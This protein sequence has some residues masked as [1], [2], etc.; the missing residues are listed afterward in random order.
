MRTPCP[1]STASALGLAIT[2]LATPAARSDAPPAKPAPAG[3]AGAF[4][5]IAPAPVA[6]PDSAGAFAALPASPAPAVLPRAR[7]PLRADLQGVL[8][9]EQ[10]QL[11]TL[12][13]ELRATPDAM[14]SLDVQRRIEKLKQQTEVELLKVQAA[15]ARRA[16]NAALADRFDEAIARIT[17][18]R[19]RLEPQARPAPA[20]AGDAR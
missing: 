18:P 20:G 14:R 10:Q 6:A 9:R 2:L 3:I 17:Q 13:V 12:E 19:P 1:R 11:A 7:T 5:R 8:D 4:A 15:H 16:G